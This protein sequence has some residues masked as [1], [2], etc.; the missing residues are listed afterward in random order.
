[1]S[2]NLVRACLDKSMCSNSKQHDTEIVCT[3]KT[4]PNIRFF[5][6]RNSKK[7]EGTGDFCPSCS[8]MSVIASNFMFGRMYHQATLA[9]WAAKP[10]FV[11]SWLLWIPPHFDTIW[12]Q[13]FILVYYFTISC[14]KLYLA[15]F[16]RVK[17]IWMSLDIINISSI[18]WFMMVLWWSYL[19]FLDLK[20]NICWPFVLFT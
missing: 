10:E 3:V 5:T 9:G 17:E 16:P 4:G 19:M 14:N 7:T 13:W 18:I 8:C 15:R 2:R 1:M 12:T 6:W 11:Q 20:I